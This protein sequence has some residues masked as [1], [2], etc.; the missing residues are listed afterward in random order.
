MPAGEA[1]LWSLLA[2]IYLLKSNKRDI[3]T[4]CEICSKLGI[5]TLEQ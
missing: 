2:A 1:I 5:K 4:G 3:R